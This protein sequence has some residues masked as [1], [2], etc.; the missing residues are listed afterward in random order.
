LVQQRRLFEEAQTSPDQPPLSDIA[1]K[2]SFQ[3]A[4]ASVCLSQT[5]AT[6]AW[7]QATELFQ[8]VVHAYEAGNDRVRQLAAESHFGLAVI[9]APEPKPQDSRTLLERAA[10]ECEKAMTLSQDSPDRERDFARHLDRIRTALSHAEPAQ[11][12][13]KGTTNPTP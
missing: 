7:Q 11:P 5:R 9:A 6:N 4:R 12:P 10:T 8:R 1:V 13:P 2:A 3:L